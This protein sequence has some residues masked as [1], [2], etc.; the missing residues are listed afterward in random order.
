MKGIKITEALLIAPITLLCA[1]PDILLV[2][3]NAQAF[4][5]ETNQEKQSLMEQKLEE[6]QA[7]ITASNDNSSDHKN[8]TAK[9]IEDLKEKADILYEAGEYSKAAEYY[10][11]IVSWSQNSLGP[12]HRDTPLP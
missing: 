6:V 3:A 2:S 1:G 5:L 10:E 4:A 8:L 7:P 11:L 12:E 9:Q